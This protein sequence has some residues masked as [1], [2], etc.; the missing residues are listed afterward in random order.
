LQVGRELGGELGLAAEAAA[1]EV[2]AAEDPANGLGYLAS[3]P[4]GSRRDRLAVSIAT[5]Y[6]RRDVEAALNWVSQQFAD[7]RVK[8]P[9][10]AVLAETDL[11]RA[12]RIDL[13]NPDTTAGRV[14]DAPNLPA[15]FGNRMITDLN[16]PAG[17]ADDIA[18]RA[19][20]KWWKERRLTAVLSQWAVDDP[21]AAITWMRA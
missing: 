2:L 12:V 3:L 4:E 18:A 7:R 9:V 19:P 6:A 11:A 13:D 5:G 8:N 16:D 17:V 15:W 14:V 1:M 21:N 20:G 10:L